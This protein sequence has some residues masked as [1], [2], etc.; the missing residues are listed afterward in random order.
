M[1]RGFFVAGTDT[2]VGKTWVGCALAR[3]ARQA[4][5]DLG[6][7][8]P[9]ETG[10]GPEGP[11]DARALREAAGV[12]DPLSDICPQTFALPAAPP[13]AAADTRREVERA[14]LEAAFRSLSARHEWMLVEGA[15]GLLVPVTEKWTMADLALAW[16]LPVLLVARAALG[17]INHTRLTLEATERRGLP[18][19]G[20]VLSHA[21]GRLSEADAS[22][23]G[24]LRTWLGPRLLA[25]LEPGQDVLPWEPFA[26]RLELASFAL[27]Q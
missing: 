24:W 7:M 1:S 11:D 23:V 18:V 22:N 4:G 14:P 16:E 17:T 5:V 20:V 21:D 10:V 8:K 27:S 9:V 25:E 15:G 19:L 12:D 6:V 26:A 3:G 13:V 2:G